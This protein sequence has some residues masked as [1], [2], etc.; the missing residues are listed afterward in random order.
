V[1]TDRGGD[2][3]VCQTSPVKVS[4]LGRENGGEGLSAYLEAKTI[5]ATL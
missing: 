1:E 2:I 4:G 5:S 3:W